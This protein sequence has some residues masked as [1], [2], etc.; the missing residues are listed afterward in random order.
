VQKDMVDRADALTLLHK[1]IGVAGFVYDSF[2]L[3]ESS[4]AL[5]RLLNAGF[6]VSKYGPISKTRGGPNGS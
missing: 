3:L 1:S 5:T 6:V 4:S 2:D